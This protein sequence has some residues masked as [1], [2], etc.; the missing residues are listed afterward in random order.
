M[1][2]ITGNRNKWMSVRFS[3]LFKTAILLTVIAVLLLGTGNQVVAQSPQVN[4]SSSTTPYDQMQSQGA[5]AN[6]QP[7]E[8]ADTIEY[9]QDLEVFDPSTI[10]ESVPIPDAD[11]VFEVPVDVKN[12]SDQVKEIVIRARVLTF[13]SG[14]RVTFGL[15]KK[16]VQL[17]DGAYKGNV[18]V[19]VKYDAS[20]ARH[21][22]SYNPFGNNDPWS[23]DSAKEYECK[24]YLIGPNNKWEN[25]T[26]SQV[27]KRW[28]MI[29]PDKPF[30]WRTGRTNL[31]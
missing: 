6:Q 27:T 9:E 23:P 8:L 22:A 4:T 18:M 31:P 13:V 14:D 25:P 3:Q 28:R 21:N 11:W 7:Q 12:L 2:F 17:V 30:K 15:A 29:N 1:G 24:I 19:G 26:K 5:Q 10:P 16:Y 20:T